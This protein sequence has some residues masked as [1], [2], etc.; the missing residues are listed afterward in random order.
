M[1]RGTEVTGLLVF[2]QQSKQIETCD[3][4]GLVNKNFE[5]KKNPTFVLC[6][7]SPAKQIEEKI[8]LAVYVKTCS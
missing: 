6:K 1:R 4:I 5:E 3:G 7:N 8:F 2:S